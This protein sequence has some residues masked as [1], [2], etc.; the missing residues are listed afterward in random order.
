M[1]L[2]RG[3]SDAAQ[4]GCALAEGLCERPKV[5]LDFSLMKYL[6]CVEKV[7]RGK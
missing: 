7:R 5:S 6:L 2:A 4:R 1:E 3:I